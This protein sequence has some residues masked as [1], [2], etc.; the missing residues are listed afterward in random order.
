MKEPRTYSI[1]DDQGIVIDNHNSLTREQAEDLMCY[2]LSLG[3]DCYLQ[4][5]D[6]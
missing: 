3:I 2:L 5:K 6:K 1:T 4:R